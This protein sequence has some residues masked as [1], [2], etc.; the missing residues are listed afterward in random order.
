VYSVREDFPILERRISRR[1]G[2]PPGGV[3]PL[4]LAYLDNAATTQKPHQ[5]LEALSNYY[6]NHNANVHRAFHT[7]GE[8]ATALY[9]EA[10]SRVREFIGAQS[11]SEI[12]FTSGTTESLNLIAGSWGRGLLKRGDEV[13]LTEMEHHSNLIPWQLLAKDKGITL[14]FIP[15]DEQGRLRLDLLETLW[16]DRIKL[17]TMVHVSNVFGT[18][19]DVRRVARFAHRRGVPILVDSAQGVPHLPVDVEDLECDFLASSGHK[20]CGPMGIGVLYGKEDWLEKMSPYQG[21]GE[22]IRSVWLERA[23]W[24]DLPYKFEAGTPNVEGA[25]GLMAAMDYLAELGMKTICRHEADL[26]QYALKRL[27]EIEGLTVYGAAPDRAGVISFNLTDVHAHDVAQ[28]LDEVGIAVRAGH[29]CA[30][31]L[32]RKLG[33]SS[34]ARASLYLYNTREEID[35]LAQALKNIKGF[36]SNAI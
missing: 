29:H 4:S 15:F 3:P 20:M 7:L 13:L 16:N 31:P 28:L 22:M 1:N 6:G 30:H 24:N 5:V 2:V 25:V 34:T 27:S 9:E 32:M 35:R 11:N 17:V 26:T 8:E 14:R 12:I 33:V 18:V 19:N 10:R 36:F 23:T 21:G